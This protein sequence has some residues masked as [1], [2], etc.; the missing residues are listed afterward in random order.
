M[1]ALESYISPGCRGDGR[2]TTARCTS[3]ASWWRS[4][5][6]S[7]S[8]P[9]RSW[10]RCRAASSSASRR[11]C[12]ARS[13]SRTAA[14]S[15][16]TSTT[17]GCMRINEAPKIEVEIVK[18]DEEPG[19]IGE[20]GTCALAPAVRECGVC[21]DRRKGP[22]AA[23]QA[24]T[25]RGDLRGDVHMRALRRVSARRC[26]SSLRSGV[27]VSGGRAGIRRARSSPLS[28]FAASPTRTERSVALFVEAGKVHRSTR[29]A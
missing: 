28:A 7:P 8:I 17:T 16:R 24:G 6:A 3:T 11:C 15:S 13:R 22:Q 14:S 23:A 12:G 19:G 18:S 9:I 25:A 29:A 2:A 20:P 5:A 10:R 26:S 21:R 1:T 27:V 4:T